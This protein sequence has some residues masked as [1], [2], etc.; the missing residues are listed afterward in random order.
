MCNAT[1]VSAVLGVVGGGLQGYGVYKQASL[2]SEDLEFQADQA[3][4]NAE[5]AAQD[6]KTTQEAAAI[7]QENIGITS[8]AARGAGRTG[9]AAGNVTVDTGTALEWDVE[10]AQ[11]SA[12]EQALTQDAADIAAQK[13][14]VERQSFLSTSRF[15]RRQAEDVKKAG[16]LSAFGTLLGSAGGTVGKFGG[17]R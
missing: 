5:L 11:L 9:F 6:I 1:A 10:Q 3:A 7:E 13:L 8:A 4:V 15:K 2:E 16:K 17:K 12:R 14:E